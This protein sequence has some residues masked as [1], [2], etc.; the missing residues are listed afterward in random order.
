M[1]WRPGCGGQQVISRNFEAFEGR[2][3]FRGTQGFFEGLQ[4]QLRRSEFRGFRGTSPNFEGSP[5][6][7]RGFRGFRG[8]PPRGPQRAPTALRSLQPGQIFRKVHPKPR[9]DDFRRFRH[10]RRLS[11]KSE[12][13]CGF[14]GNLSKFAMSQSTK[15]KAMLQSWQSANHKCFIAY[16][17]T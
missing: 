5:V 17:P 15:A 10:F 7:F 8:T 14:A 16:Q 13:V 2:P 9:S 4:E 12:K 1:A 6:Q 3:E 11:D